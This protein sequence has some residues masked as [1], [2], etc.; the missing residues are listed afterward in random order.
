MNSITIFAGSRP[1]S[2]PVFVEAAYALGAACAQ[3]GIDVWYGG[4]PTGCMGALR[5][6]VMDNAGVI[7]AVTPGRIF[8]DE[9]VLPDTHVHRVP[10]MHARQRAMARHGEAFI[11]L[12]GGLGT[13]A[14]LFEVLTFLQ[15]GVLKG[16]V[17]GVLDIEGFYDAVATPLKWAMQHGFAEPKHVSSL[18]HAASVEDLLRRVADAVDQQMLARASVVRLDATG[19]RRA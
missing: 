17:V 4:G 18:M 19:G 5:A 1:G 15:I 14:E 16:K 8:R 11:A 13:D 9:G 10:N 7:H 12:P 6:G 2:L 3:R